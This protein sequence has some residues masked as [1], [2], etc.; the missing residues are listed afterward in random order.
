MEPGRWSASVI[1]GDGNHHYRDMLT[2]SKAYR[3]V[4][5][6]PI[7]KNKLHTRYAGQ[8]PKRQPKKVRSFQ[9]RKRSMS[10]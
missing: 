1:D 2:E 6:Y 8:I 3:M 7:G 9:H 4:L 5:G 10:Y